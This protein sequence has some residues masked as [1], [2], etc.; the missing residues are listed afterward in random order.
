MDSN[1]LPLHQSPYKP[2]LFLTK[3]IA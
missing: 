1:V 2:A 3:T